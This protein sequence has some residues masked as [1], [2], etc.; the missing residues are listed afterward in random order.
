MNHPELTVEILRKTMHYDIATGVFTWLVN[1]GRNAQIG[2]VAGTI[3]KGGYIGI[4]VFQKRYQAHRL[5]WFYIRGEWP[6]EIDHKN[7]VKTDNSIDNMR[8]VDRFINCQNIQK[9]RKNN[10]GSGMLGAH[11]QGSGKWVASIGVNGKAKYLGLFETPELAHAAYMDA[12]RVLH[13]GCLI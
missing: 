1:R 5:A 4:T 8:D 2:Q 13:E 7:L 11:K 3:T 10:I 9:P 6:N 12:K